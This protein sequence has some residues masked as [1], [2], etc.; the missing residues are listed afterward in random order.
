MAKSSHQVAKFTALHKIL[1]RKYV[2]DC[3]I[4]PYKKNSEMNCMELVIDY[5]I[6]LSLKDSDCWTNQQASSCFCGKKKDA[7]A[8]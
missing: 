3:L 7:L 6:S 2:L 4:L 1:N 8:M 5:K